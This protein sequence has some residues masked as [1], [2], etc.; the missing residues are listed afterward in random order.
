MGCDLPIPG[1]ASDPEV[2]IA[3]SDFAFEPAKFNIERGKKTIVVL[4][5]QGTVEHSFALPK[6]PNLAPTR[7]GPGQTARAEIALAPGTYQYVCIIEGH[8]QAG[9]VGQITAARPR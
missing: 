7:V 5:N 2:A 1:R 4:E 3:L 9:M 6:Q 8:E